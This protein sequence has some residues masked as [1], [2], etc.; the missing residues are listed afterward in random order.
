MGKVVNL[1][2]LVAVPLFQAEGNVPYRYGS[3]LGNCRHHMSDIFLSWKSVTH[4]SSDL[5]SYI[6]YDQAPSLPTY[7]IL[8]DFEKHKK[9][10][11]LETEEAQRKNF[12]NGNNL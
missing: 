11:N 1:E 6:N 8:V 10:L 2:S 7:K 4:G 5:T 12:E 3:R 9:V